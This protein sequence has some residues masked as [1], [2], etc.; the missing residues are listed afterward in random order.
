MDCHDV[1]GRFQYAHA[2]LISAEPVAAGSLHIP[3][4]DQAM[5]A[6]CV[7]RGVM[8][9]RISPVD[10]KPYAIGFEMRLPLPWNGRF[11]YQADG[12]L[13]GVIAPAY[14][15]ILSGG[16]KSNGLLKG[17]AVI[18]T[19][20]GHEM[21]RNVPGIGGALF[22]VDPQARLDYGYNA[23]ATLTP[24]AKALIHTYYG[25]APDRSYLVGASNGG[26]HAMVA[27]ARDTGEYD[28]IVAGA[29]GFHLPRAAVAQLW[30]AQQFARVASVSPLTGRPD[31]TTSFS[32]ADMAVLSRH[33]LARCDALD[34]LQ[35]G[36]IADV[37]ACQKVFDVQ[38]DVPTCSS[39]QKG[40]CLTL[41]QKQ[42]LVAVFAGPKDSKGQQWYA[43]LPWD[44]GVSGEDWRN[45][46][47]VYSVGPRDAVA[48][49]YVFSTPPA[50]PAQVSGQGNTLI[51]YVLNFSLERD[52]RAIYAGNSRYTQSAM[53][54]MTP[55]D[56]TRM[57]HFTRRGGK[58]IVFHGAS[59]PVF[60][61][62]DTVKWYEGFMAEHGAGGR[63]TARLFI[64]PGMNHTRYGPAADQFDMVEAMMNWVEKGQVPE[65][66]VAS[67]RGGAS[68]V[69]N[70][71]LPAD[72]SASRTRLLCPY[73]SVARY[74][75]KGDTESASHFRCE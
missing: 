42:V 28:G 22:G 36:I 8:N 53:Q 20:A 69:P 30:D 68:T 67:V 9:E 5:P 24:M 54:F 11:F 74:T 49:A 2:R 26:R 3:G 58:L 37:M 61:A 63:N 38:R 34:G 60:S 48:V 10:G 15:A 33:I 14:G 50:S 35:D 7:V 46:K 41:P 75:G 31:L 32:T 1:V 23:V 18:S 27:A 39:G 13:D 45:W 12:G 17:F 65:Q 55:P 62:L 4:I 56:E 59:D 16:P 52:A 71:E 21:E 47:F 72:W 57:D 43:P 66:I 29:P 40:D 70:K 6:H 44:A 25:K 51:D 73:P 19:N 64:V